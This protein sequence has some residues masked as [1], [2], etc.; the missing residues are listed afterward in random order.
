[1]DWKTQHQIRQ[2]LRE[3]EALLVRAS[4]ADPVGLPS[5]VADALRYVISFARLTDLRTAEGKDIELAERLARHRWWVIHQLRPPLVGDPDVARLRVLLPGLRSETL[6]IRAKLFQG[7]DVDPEDLEEEVCTRQLILSMGGGGG[8]GYGYVGVLQLLHRHG[9]QP[10]L[11]AGTSIGALIGMFRSRALPFD[12][13]ALIEAGKKLKWNTVFR[14]LEMNSKYGVPATLRLYLRHA[15]S[16]MLQTPDGRHMTFRD[17]PI[18]LLIVATGLTVEAFKHDMSYYEHFMDDA[19][20]AGTVFRLSRLRRMAKLIGVFQEFLSNPDSLREVVFGADEMTLDADVIDAAGFSAAIPGLIHYDVVRDDP[21]MQKLL[22][23][24]YSE[25]GIT[26]LGEG[27]LVNNLPSRPAL[28]SVLQGRIGR[29]NPFLLAMDC[30]TPQPSSLVWY[31][32]QQF[33]QYNVR[34]NAP[35]SDFTYALGRRLPAMN[36]VP[37]VRQMGKAMNWSRE[38]FAQHIPFV[39]RMC[40]SHGVLEAEG[41]RSRKA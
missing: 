22:D 18:P 15:L 30:F 6:R 8:G 12:Q 7:G 5:D 11:I 35:F 3:L 23:Q 37:T 36:V 16:G 40:A 20:R 2:P 41:L 26:R 1:L 25:H 33:V 38:E 29:R 28:T 27:G 24:L 31:P 9:L 13:S 19:V 21:Q 32:V 34:Q 17:C 10:Q 39:S 14:V 4:M